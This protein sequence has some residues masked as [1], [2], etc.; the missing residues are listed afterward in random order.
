VTR[1][2]SE[3]SARYHIAGVEGVHFQMAPYRNPRH[4]TRFYG[5]GAVG[6][7]AKVKSTVALAAGAYTRSHFCST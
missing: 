7:A 6:N 3:I 4:A 5:L 1:L 2:A